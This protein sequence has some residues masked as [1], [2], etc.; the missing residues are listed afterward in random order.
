MKIIF[1]NVNTTTHTGESEANGVAFSN[2]LF[3]YINLYLNAMKYIM[4]LNH[5]I[6]C[7]IFIY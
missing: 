3:L 6:E 1:L 7:H 5:V 4:K 2:E